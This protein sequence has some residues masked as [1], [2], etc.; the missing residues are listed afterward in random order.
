MSSVVISLKRKGI[1]VFLRSN[2]NFASRNPGV[3]WFVPSRYAF[4]IPSK[5]IRVRGS[6]GQALRATIRDQ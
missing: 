5:N 2:R 4:V 6:R 3:H 1:A